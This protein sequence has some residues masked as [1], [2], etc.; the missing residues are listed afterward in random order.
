MKYLGDVVV[1]EDE[2]DLQKYLIKYN[3]NS[4]ND[5]SEILWYEFGVDVRYEE[6]QK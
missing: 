5:L 4:F 1:L 6:K 2:N 3:C